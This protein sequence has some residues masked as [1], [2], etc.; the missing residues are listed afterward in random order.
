VRSTY[1]RDLTQLAAEWLASCRV[2]PA[3]I[4]ARMKQRIQQQKVE[5]F[6]TQYEPRK[7]VGTNTDLGAARSELCQVRCASCGRHQ[8]G[9]LHG[10]HVQALHR[11][12]ELEQSAP[13]STRDG[14]SQRCLRGHC[15][16]AWRCGRLLSWCWR[17][18]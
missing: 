5:L 13:P 1:R 9:E 8:A 17:S 11:V 14:A 16:I 10:A 7:I 4:C 6:R 3:K 18:R 15:G 12:H 2:R